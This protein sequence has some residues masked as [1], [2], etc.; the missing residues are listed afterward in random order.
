MSKEKYQ[1][2]IKKARQ[3]LKRADHLA[4]MTYPIV[5]ENKL[6]VKILE[7]IYDSIKFSINAI[8]QYE[9]LYKRI[10]IYKDSKENFRTFKKIASRYD[11]DKEQLEKIIKIMKLGQRHKNSPFE[12]GKD[13]KLVIMSNNNK[14]DTLTIEKIKNQLIEA[15]DLLRKVR[16]KTN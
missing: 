12:F 13:N 6:L 2:S 9:Y 7:Q 16:N 5:K 15:K 4:Y 3:V 1:T 8:L 10:K 14:T 11:I